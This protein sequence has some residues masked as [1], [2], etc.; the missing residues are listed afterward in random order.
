MFGAPLGGDS[1]LERAAEEGDPHPGIKPGS[2]RS[3]RV[4]ANTI[5]PSI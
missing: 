4:E 3:V 5:E 2:T 1:A